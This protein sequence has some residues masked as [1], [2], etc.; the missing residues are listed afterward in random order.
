MFVVR[1]EQHERRIGIPLLDLLHERVIGPAFAHFTPGF[2]RAEWANL[3]P[4]FAIRADHVRVL[5]RRQIEVGLVVASEPLSHCVARNEM[6]HECS[7]A[8]SLMTGSYSFR[9]SVDVFLTACGVVRLEVGVDRFVRGRPIDPRQ[10]VAALSASN[11]QLVRRKQ[12][13]LYWPPNNS[14]ERPT[15]TDSPRRSDWRV[16]FLADFFKHPFFWRRRILRPIG[17][18]T[19]TCQAVSSK[20]N[21]ASGHGFLR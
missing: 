1:N 17:S 9:R 7:R 21:D 18:L 8:S 16:D 5:V 2:H 12:V 3:P 13:L 4:H 10:D 20:K 19:A 6:R 14:N 15:A 11:C